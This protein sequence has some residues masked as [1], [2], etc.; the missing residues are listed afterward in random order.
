MDDRIFKYDLSKVAL[1]ETSLQHCSIYFSLILFFLQ[2][3]FFFCGV[4]FELN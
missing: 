4:G 2:T 1:Q 3:L